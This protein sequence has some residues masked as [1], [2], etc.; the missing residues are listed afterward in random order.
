[1]TVETVALYIVE[2]EKC[3]KHSNL[4]PYLNFISSF[5][6]IRTNLRFTFYES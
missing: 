6:K 2:I 5:E 3:K 1:M 4:Y